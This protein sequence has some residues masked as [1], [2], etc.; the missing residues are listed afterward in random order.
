MNP[1]TREERAI[2]KIDVL[3][4]SPGGGGYS[5]PVERDPELVR[6]DVANGFVT[7]A[8]AAERYGVVLRDGAVDAGE[9][10]RRRE[11]RASAPAEFGFGPEREPYERRLP[12]AVQDAVTASEQ[13][14][15]ILCSAETVR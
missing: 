7:L 14:Q 6:Q 8:E 11:R 10:R 1:W 15:A 5:D 9:T 12:P 2:G 3:K 13:I 4:L